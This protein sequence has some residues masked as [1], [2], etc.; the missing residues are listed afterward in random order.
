MGD[1][2]HAVRMPRRNPQARAGIAFVLALL[3]LGVVALKV[4]PFGSDANCDGGAETSPGPVVRAASVSLSAS[5]SIGDLYSTLDV[6]DLV[7]LVSSV[8]AAGSGRDGES[9]HPRVH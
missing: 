9:P 4:L 2:N 6:S 5:T 3:L 7:V 8:R 1:K